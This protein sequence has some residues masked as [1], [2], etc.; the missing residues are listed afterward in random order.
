MDK[1]FFSFDSPEQS[2]GFQLW[3]TANAWQNKLKKQ[4]ASLNLSPL[5]LVLLTSLYWL[6]VNKGEA[7][8]EHIA[9][10]ANVGK[11]TVSKTL[12]ALEKKHLIQR[13]EHEVDTR[14]KSISINNNGMHTLRK[15]ISLVEKCDEL[16][17]SSIRE[18]LSPFAM[19]LNQ[20]N[21]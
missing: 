8:Q 7:T 16:F 4:L 5:E 11:M 12:R 6:I 1:K 13:R 9:Q 2:V 21:D 18:K 20:L 3:K 10:H 14:A 17:F 19:L 15:A